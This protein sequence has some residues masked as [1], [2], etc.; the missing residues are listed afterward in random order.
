MESHIE[1]YAPGGVRPEAR[2]PYTARCFSTC[3][4][5]AAND[6][7][8]G[9]HIPL[10]GGRCDD[11]REWYASTS[12]STT[13]PKT[14]PF[15]WCSRQSRCS[16]SCSPVSEKSFEWPARQTGRPVKSPTNRRLTFEEGA[17]M[18]FQDKGPAWSGSARCTF[19]ADDVAASAGFPQT[20]R[21][22]GERRQSR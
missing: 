15:S 14:K 20:V 16:F 8:D 9:R 22:A 4:K 11:R 1:A 12:T 2:P 5:G 18:S 6:V 19:H 3:S 10:E 21:N 7:H 17:R 13:I